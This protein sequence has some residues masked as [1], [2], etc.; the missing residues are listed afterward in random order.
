[1]INKSHDRCALAIHDVTCRHTDVALSAPVPYALFLIPLDRLYVKSECYI[2]AIYFMDLSRALHMSRIK[3][4]LTYKLILSKLI[5]NWIDYIDY[6]K[7]CTHIVVCMII[8]CD[9][10]K[11]FTTYTYFSLCYP[12]KSTVLITHLHASRKKMNNR[13][14]YT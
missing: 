8:V 5:R 12:L 3:L 7:F 2:G 10:P 6:A 4:H 14:L 11:L 13:Q 1:M 9:S